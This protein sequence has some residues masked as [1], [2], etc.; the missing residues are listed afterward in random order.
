MKA[1]P[2]TYCK[3]GFYSP[4]STASYLEISD[5]RCWVLKTNP[6]ALTFDRRLD[7]TDAE[8]PV[9]FENDQITLNPYSVA[10]RVDLVLEC[11]MT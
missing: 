4:S 5:P 1:W 10:S 8:T 6:I 2:V 11:V 3:L 7:S 9:K